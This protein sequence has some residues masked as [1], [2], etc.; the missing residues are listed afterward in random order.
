M[1]EWCCLRLLGLLYTFS[2]GEYQRL[3]S[4]HLVWIITSTS[5]RLGKYQF[6]LLSGLRKVTNV[7]NNFLWYVTISKTRISISLYSCSWMYFKVFVLYLK[8]TSS[9]L[10]KQTKPLLRQSLSICF[11]VIIKCDIF[12]LQAFSISSSK[13]SHQYNT[14]KLTQ[15]L[16]FAHCSK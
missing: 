4:T 2:V 15:I 14:D 6:S 5:R 1:I 16:H 10:S 9:F 13:I 12:K 3:Y 11:R 7:L 8:K